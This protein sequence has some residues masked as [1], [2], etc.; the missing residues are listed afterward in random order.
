MKPQFAFLLVVLLAPTWLFSQSDT[1]IQDIRTHYKEVQRNIQ[2][3]KDPENPGGYYCNRVQENLYSGS[4]RAT[5]QYTKTIAYWYNDVPGM[6]CEEFGGNEACH[7]Q[8]IETEEA[9]GHGGWA[10]EYLFDKGTL[11]FCFMVNEAG[12]HRFYW[13]EGKLIRAQI[14]KDIQEGEKI[15]EESVDISEE[16]W[17]SGMQYRKHYIDQF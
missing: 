7:L 4:W 12:Q 10:T 5:G 8:F 13:Q 6:A 17:Q 2:D 11:V 14:D 1:P 3:A 16:L 15:E 9:Y